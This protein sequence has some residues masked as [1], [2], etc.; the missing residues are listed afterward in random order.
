MQTFKTMII[1]EA[2]VNHNGDLARAL[3][4]VDVAADAG[5]DW[6]KFQTFKAEKIATQNAPKAQ[7]QK[8]STDRNEDQL[9]MLR[10]LELSSS[11][12][13]ALM[14]RCQQK[15]I[16]FMSTA[17]DDESLDL[18]IRLRLEIFKVPSGELNN[19]P[20]LRRMGALNK[21][22]IVSTGMA[23]LEEIHDALN[24]LTTAGTPLEKITVLHC[25]SQYPAP[26][27]EV[28][29]RVIPE[30]SQQLGAKVGYSDHTLGIE[31]SIAAV[32][33]GATVIEKHF[34][35]DRGLEGPDHAASLEPKEFVSMV[36]AIRHIEQAMGTSIKQPTPSELDTAL[37]VRKS[38]VAARKIRCGEI[39][40][41]EN[42]ATKRPGTGISPMQWDEWVGRVA[43]RDYEADELIK[44]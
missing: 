24:V 9:A 28:N 8:K 37:V 11:D 6:V 26:F 44:P 35:L 31:V 36:A 14:E 16:G 22:L 32:A 19:L 18:L 38:I 27:P 34:T 13:E 21:Q 4:L 12:H 40:S 29:L 1:A 15:G 23:N 2:G 41:A 5:A 7:Y 17:F 3:E 42:L 30:L 43:Q 10:R 33:L 39:L 25:T 20:Y